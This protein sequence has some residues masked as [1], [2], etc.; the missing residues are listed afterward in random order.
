MARPLRIDIPQSIYHVTSRGLERRNIVSDDL[1]RQR[2]TDLLSRVAS[3]RN[4]RLFAWALMDN[5]FHLFLRVPHADLS[6]G[7]HDLNCSYVSVFNRRHKRCGP[8]LQGRFKGILVESEYHYWE[9]TR[10]VHLNPVRAGLTP[11]P[12]DYRWSSCALYFRPHLAP[13]WLGWE[14]VL[15]EHGDSMPLAQQ[16]Y[17][18]FLRG[19]QDANHPSPLDMATA[20]TLLGS[21]EYVAQIKEWLHGR[22]L[23]REVPAATQLRKSHE[24]QDIV[25]SVCTVFGFDRN[26]LLRRGSRR[27]RPRA[28]ALYLCRSMTRCSVRELGRYF[29]DINGQAVSNI[30]TKIQLELKRDVQLSQQV[31]AAEELLH[32]RWK[33]TT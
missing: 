20:S 2:W 32:A 28:I 19:D 4:W 9:L 10:Y 17:R 33:M 22:P 14:E 11:D 3:R 26:H 27:N 13:D 30:V 25:E 1:D 12:E 23:C 5:H 29:G 31:R 18:G 21:Q 8:L 24:V 6:Q 16:A 7:M 15:L